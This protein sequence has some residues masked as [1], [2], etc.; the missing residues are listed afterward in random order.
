MNQG[1]QCKT[2][3]KWHDELPMSFGVDAPYWYDVIAPEELSWRAELS[4]D[5][6]IIDNQHY[7][8]RGYI[9]IPVLDDLGPFV[10]DVWVSLSE[11][12][13]ERMSELWETPGR[14]SEA[15]YFGWFST[16]LPGYPETL[17]LKTTVHTRPLGERPLIELEPTDHPLAVEQREG[18][19]MARVQEIVEIVLHGGASP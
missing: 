2:C 10:W 9:E 18:I 13:F 11:Q 4:S 1:Y 12:S 3:E 6:C 14:E 15:P 8:V 17:N 5:Q 16:S 7:F 19:T